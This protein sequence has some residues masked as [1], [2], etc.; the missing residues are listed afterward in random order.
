MFGQKQGMKCVMSH[1]L[2]Q[3]RTGRPDTRTRQALDRLVIDTAR[4]LFTEQGY[5]A[6]SVEQI[7]SAASV[8]KQTVYRRYPSKDALFRQVIEDLTQNIIAV[9]VQS[10]GGGSDPLVLLRDTLRALWGVTTQPDTTALLRVLATETKRMPDV[11]RYVSHELSDQV[12]QTLTK[13]IAAAQATAQ[14]RRDIEPE[15]MARLMASLYS[16]LPTVRGL[17]DSPILTTE[18]QKD[19]F[20]EA[21]WKLLLSS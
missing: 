20:F 6:T 4:R 18:A 21:G 13:L 16:G 5:A 3:K 11:V 9:A 17:L 15:L 1:F 12:H 8:G 7:A 10:E 14:V 19:A 2:P